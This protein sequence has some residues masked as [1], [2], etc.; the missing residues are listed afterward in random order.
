MKDETIVTT[1]YTKEGY[2]QL[3]DEL[4]N[5]KENLRVQ[6]KQQLAEARSHGD[7]SENSEYDEARDAQAKNESRIQELEEA[8]KHAEIVDETAIKSG[9]VNIGSTVVVY[10]RTFDE[11]VTYSIVGSNEVDAFAN[12]ISDSSPIGAA[13]VGKRKGDVVTFNTPGGEVELEIKKVSRSKKA[14]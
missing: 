14:N 10:D 5:R 9:V 1:K 13:L 6:I 8:I 11:E 12:L 7:L 3:L 4:A 2:Q